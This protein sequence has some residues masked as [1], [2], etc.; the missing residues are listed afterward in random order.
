MEVYFG[1]V[2]MSGR[3]L[4]VGEGGRNWFLFTTG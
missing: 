1:E 2:E 3:F 4:W